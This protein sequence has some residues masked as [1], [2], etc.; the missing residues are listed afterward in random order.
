MRTLVTGAAGFIGS[1]LCEALLG[2]GH[3]VRGV[4][5]FTPAY[6]TDLK[7]DNLRD[8]AADPAF[9]FVRA[10]LRTVELEPLLDGIEVVFHL[11]GQP[12]VRPSWAAGFRPYVEHNVVATQRLLHAA[13]EHPLRRFVYASSSSVYGNAA[14]YPTRETDLT[15]PHSPYAVTKLA[16]EHMCGVYAHNYGVP[17]TM[18][19]YF[20]VYGPRQ[21]PD[22][23]IHR[24]I[25]AALLGMPLPVFGDGT[26]LRDFTYVADVVAATFRAGFADL[27]PGTVLNVAGGNAITV[28]DLLDIIE[29]ETGG[30]IA[31]RRLPS[32]AGDVEATGGSIELAGAL[33]GWWPRVAIEHGVAAQVAWQ[34]GTPRVIVPEPVEE[35]VEAVR[36]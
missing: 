28:N 8:L 11:A 9:D 30:P 32:Q 2:A 14:R 6:D 5:A 36:A 23:G 20:T 4:D 24:F 16:A 13:H 12:G 34:R 7:Q 3:E 1:H 15:N 31:I 17:T 29:W 10:D 18:L 19:R 26:Q 25:R 33:L 35:A 27:T 22:M 21:R